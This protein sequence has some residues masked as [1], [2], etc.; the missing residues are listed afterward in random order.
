MMAAAAFAQSERGNITGSVTDSSGAPVPAAP[1]TITN[2]ATNVQEHVVTTGSGSYNAPNLVPGVYRV[3]VAVSGFRSFVLDNL[4]VT[5]GATVR[6]HDPEAMEAARGLWGDRVHFAPEPYAALDGADALAVVT[7][8]LVYRNPDFDRI[9]ATLRQPV[10]VDGRNLY[11]PAEMTR[12]GFRYAG[13][14][15]RG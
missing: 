15:R 9:R 3:E 5:A 14:G 6:A 2:T 13:I 1:V 8:W 12:R 7:E 11:E 10:L 4:T